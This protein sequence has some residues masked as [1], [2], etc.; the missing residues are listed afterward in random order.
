[1]KALIGANLIDGTGGPVIDDATVLIDGE[2]IVETGPRAA[3]ELPPNTEIVDL[4][5]MT[6][7]P[8]LID[9]HDHLAS[10]DYGLASRMGIN[11]PLSLQHLR[12]AKV[13]EQTLAAGY[14]CVRDA[15]GLD[16]GFKQAVEQGLY[17]GPR[18]VISVGIISPTGGLADKVT[19]SGHGYP[20][21]DPLV[22]SGVANGDD[23][24]RSKVREMARVGADVIKFATTGGAS[25]RPGHGPLDIA[26]GPSEVRALIRRGPGAGPQDN[27]PRR[28]R[29]RTAHVHRGGRPFGRTRLL[30]GGRP[31]PTQD[32]GRQRHFPGAYFRDL[33][34]S[35]H[36][37]RTAYAKTGPG[38]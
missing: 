8:G 23:P 6:L 18:L 7:L 31:G 9:C 24:V 3:V 1:M 4:S 2:R 5:G 37:Q 14:T 10:K 16:V 27:V 26:Y 36:T 11:E 12:T 21:E 15:G 17:P 13:L 25:S 32:D 38:R 28:R 33:R 29:P 19:S 35:R 20:H 30:P 22:P 34:V